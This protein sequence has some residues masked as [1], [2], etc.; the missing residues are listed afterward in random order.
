MTGDFQLADGVLRISDGTRY[1][2]SQQFAGRED[3]TEVFIPGSVGFM[4]EEVFAECRNLETVHLP[5][6][7]VN[8]GVAAFTSCEKLQSISIPQ[9]V[10]AVEDG[11]FLS[12]EAL[13]EVFLPEKLETISALA[14]QETGLETVSVPAGVR[15][16]GEEAFFGCP[17]L[18][19]ADVL[20]KNTRICL[21]AFGSSYSLT[22]GYIAPG[23]PDEKSAPAEL[24]YSMLWATCPER[25]TKET[26]LRAEAFIRSNEALIMEKIFRNSNIPALTGIASR[27]LLRPEN[28]DGYVK[29]ALELN[30][31]EL[32]ALLL[33]AK[34]TAR[35]TEGE[36]E[37]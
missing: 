18:R 31:T 3:I 27:R 7:L 16:I 23:F 25:H 4:E 24:L 30:L 12:C 11:A 6:G 34:G 10:K 5:S 14:F 1:L 21:N 2:K 36:F 26:N 13:R 29:K 15:E 19:R 33:K 8:I 32:T 9:S 35:D 28:I 20:G 37:L 17:S 22:E